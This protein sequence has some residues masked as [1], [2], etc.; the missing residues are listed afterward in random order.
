MNADLEPIKLCIS[1][2]SNANS[3]TGRMRNQTQREA[4]SSYRNSMTYIHYSR[5]QHTDAAGT[6]L[7]NTEDNH[8]IHKLLKW[9][10]GIRSCLGVT[11]FLRQLRLTDHL[12][13]ALCI[14]KI[15]RRQT[16]LSKSTK[17]T[18]F[19]ECDAAKEQRQTYHLML[20]AKE[21]RSSLRNLLDFVYHLLLDFYY[22]RRLKKSVVSGI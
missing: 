15:W 7:Q 9:L 21:R 6:S 14:M 10:F 19:S 13:N 20:W 22:W 8:D 12:F 3:S 11:V 4:T 16:K 17:L 5:Q 2:K 18:W 1:L